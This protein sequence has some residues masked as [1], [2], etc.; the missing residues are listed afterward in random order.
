MHIAF[1][2]TLGLAS[3]RKNYPSVTHDGGV[4][5]HDGGIVPHHVQSH[6]AAF[7]SFGIG[8]V[9]KG[10]YGWV[11]LLHLPWG[12]QDVEDLSLKVNKFTRDIIYDA[13]HAAFPV[14]AIGLAGK[15]EQRPKKTCAAD[16]K[17]NVVHLF[18]GKGCNGVG[19]NGG[20]HA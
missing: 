5:L 20:E 4:G 17:P 9:P 12:F 16:E 19:L 18:A 15:R 13:I 11:V 2:C 14:S 7:R 10:L 3:Y 6:A 8:L 1:N